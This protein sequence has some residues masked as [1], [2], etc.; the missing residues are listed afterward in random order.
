MCL[1]LNVCALH[2]VDD[3]MELIAPRAAGAN[4]AQDRRTWADLEAGLVW[5]PLM[6]QAD[7]DR[8]VARRGRA[9]R[10]TTWLRCVCVA[11]RCCQQV[12]HFTATTERK[13][14]TE[15][16]FTCNIH[17]ARLA[18]MRQ[19]WIMPASLCERDHHG[20]MGQPIKRIVASEDV[21]A[22]YQE[23]MQDLLSVCA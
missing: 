14:R 8:H 3:K 19:W 5:E 23:T 16:I 9:E 13:S 6:E 17:A 4:I 20:A 11:D 1:V 22:E 7:K 10:V 21:T 2:R 15:V 12:T 18:R